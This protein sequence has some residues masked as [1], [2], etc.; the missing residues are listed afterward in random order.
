LLDGLEVV[1][2]HTENLL[3]YSFA[4]S[5]T[6]GHLSKTHAPDGHLPTTMSRDDRPPIDEGGDLGDREKSV[7]PLC[8]LGEI[9]RRRLECGC[10]GTIP[11]AVHAMTR[12][13][14]LHKHV[15]CLGSGCEE[16]AGDRG[17]AARAI[18]RRMHHTTP[19]H[20]TVPIRERARI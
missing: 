19:M 2:K 3:D 11:T 7:M 8:N 1:E 4:S 17:A 15:R 16:T 6:P 18:P 14:I 5:A 9:S 20:V 12:A 10:S 13:T